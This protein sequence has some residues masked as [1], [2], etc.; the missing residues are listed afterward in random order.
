MIQAF[1][2]RFIAKEAEIK[3]RFKAKKPDSYDE[4]VAAMV[5]AVADEEN[6]SSDTPDPKRIH[7]IDDGDYQGTI[8]FVIAA[9][10][11]QP[12]TYWSVFVSYGS[13]SG[14]DTLQAINEESYDEIT[15]GQVQQWYTLAL[16]AV[17]E[18]KLIGEPQ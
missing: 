18:M 5:E 1:V 7:R 12:S 10:G 11:Y 4:I 2:D 17:Q 8:L 3:A 16:H 14:C 6:W 15:D 13:C 9:K